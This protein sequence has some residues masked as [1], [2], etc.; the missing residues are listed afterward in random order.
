MTRIR[1]RW[2]AGTDRIAHAHRPGPWVRALCGAIEE[3][4]AWPQLRRCMACEA[5][6]YEAE[7]GGVTESEMRMLWG[8]R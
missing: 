1:I 7:H 5:L 6:V 2:T 8:D 3:R 4:P